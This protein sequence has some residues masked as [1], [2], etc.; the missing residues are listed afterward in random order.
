MDPVSGRMRLSHLGI[1]MIGR[2]AM[3]E[4]HNNNVSINEATAFATKDQNLAN[5]VPNI[6]RSLL[7]LIEDRGHS[8]ERLCLGLGFNYHDLQN[9]D[10]LLSHRQVRE[11][12]LRAQ[13][14][15]ADPAL[16][17][18]TGA[19]ET[20]V[21]WGIAGL[22]M[23]TC[24]TFGEAVNYGITHQSES[25]AMLDHRFEDR[26]RELHI[27]LIP[28]IFDLRIERFLVEEAFASV[29]AVSR[30]MVGSAFSPV[31]VDLGY[32][33]PADSDQYER[34]FRCPIRFAAGG[35][36]IT[37]ESHWLGARL[38]GYD[39]I[40][41]G[42]VREQLN[43]LLKR[44]EG[45]HDLVE[46]LSSRIRFGMEDRLR[47]SDLAREVNVSERTLRRRLGAQELGY[48]KLRDTSLFERARDLLANSKMTINEVALA[49]GYS[50]ARAFRRAFKRWSG[51]LPTTFRRVT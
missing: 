33:S 27:D 13:E 26:G 41:C 42:L 45:R 25:G 34:L 44:P 18:A 4:I 50:D 17:L 3:S 1:V 46:S 20:P 39:R 28:R 37:F 35:H 32:E 43:T 16:G 31:R 38:P 29:V 5:I 8:A 47:Q 14:L 36:R 7:G 11:L 9:R 10:V 24:E 48:R 12:I 51:Q 2:A 23:Y 49:V 19:R 6:A 30:C 15:T 40:T 21:S 22:A